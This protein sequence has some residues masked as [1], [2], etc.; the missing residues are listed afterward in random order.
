MKVPVTH[1]PE[2]VRTTFEGFP[3]VSVI[4]E[5]PRGVVFV[6]HGSGGGVGVV[7]KVE[8]TDILKELVARGYGW[9]ATESTLRTDTKRW[10]VRHATAAD[11][12]DLA[13]LDRLWTHLV[14]TTAAAATTPQL[15]LGM[16]NGARFVSLWAEANRIQG[17]PVAAVAQMMGRAVPPVVRVPT[18]FVTAL[19]DATPDNA[20]I[21]RDHERAIA[22]GTTAQLVRIAERPM[23]AHRLVR[24]PGMTPDLATLV[25]ASLQAHGVTDAAGHRA[26]APDAV[27][28]ALTGL[29]LPAS[30]RPRRA[31]I[32]DQVRAAF[33]LHELNAEPKLAI[34]TFF[35]QATTP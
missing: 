3:V 29:P 28:G 21:E 16:S 35:D 8:A 10:D 22:A 23:S 14:A 30:I 33:A 11:N 4:P 20:D 17:D 31:D 12:P 13:R 26:V 25:M 24:I 7:D 34:G 5:D 15:G 19:N 6:F 1:R 2:P 27:D 32:N 9:V 18:I